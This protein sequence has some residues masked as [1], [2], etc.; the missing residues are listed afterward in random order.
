MN[1]E[2]Y[3]SLE[4]SDSKR[5]DVNKQTKSPSPKKAIPDWKKNN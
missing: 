5:K 3:D 1:I 2:T 4:R